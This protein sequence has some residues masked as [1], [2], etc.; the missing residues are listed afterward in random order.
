MSLCELNCPLFSDLWDEVVDNTEGKWYRV[1]DRTGSEV[2]LGILYYYGIEHTC[3]Y[4][5]W[6]YMSYVDLDSADDFEWIRTNICPGFYKDLNEGQAKLDVDHENLVSA[7]FLNKLA[8]QLSETPSDDIALR[9]NTWQPIDPYHMYTLA[10]ASGMSSD[11]SQV[12]P[13]SAIVFEKF[14]DNSVRAFYNDEEFTP[15]GCVLGET[16]LAQAVIDAL[17]AKGARSDYAA[18]CAE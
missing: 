7:G 18:H 13:G 4:I 15:I 5:D 12:M 11:S 9:Y 2:T 3:S 10:A 8:A 17:T 1:A 6:A 14:E 16:C